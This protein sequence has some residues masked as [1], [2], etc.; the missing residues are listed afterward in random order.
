M[1]SLGRN[2][3]FHH[4]SQAGCIVSVWDAWILD[5]VSPRTH[6]GKIVK[7]SLELYFFSERRQTF[8]TVDS[9]ESIQS[10]LL[11][12]FLL[13][14]KH[15]KKKLHVPVISIVLLVNAWLF[16]ELAAWPS[17]FSLASAW[18]KLP[19]V[20]I[21]LLVKCFILLGIDCLAKQSVFLTLYHCHP[22][23]NPL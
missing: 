20:S 8:L 19:V 17:F 5:L 9:H 6:K 1:K 22:D 16:L 18:K 23:S 3:I 13:G 14:L 4:E 7:K 10:T 11:F 2:K 15:E 21:V 12:F